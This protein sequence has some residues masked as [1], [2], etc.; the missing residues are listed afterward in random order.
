MLKNYFKL[1]LFFLAINLFLIKNSYSEIVKEIKVIGNDRISSKTIE[2]FANVSINDNL[3]QSNINQILKDLYNTNFFNND[4][5]TLKNNVLMISVYENP[6]INKIQI[7][8][9]KSKRIKDLILKNSILKSRSSFDQLLLK[10]DKENIKKTLKD[11]GY[12]F[13]SVETFIEDLNNNKIN[14]KY[15]FNLG[16]KAKIKKISFIGDKKFKDRKLKS[17][18]VSEENKFWKFITNKKFVNEGIISL[19]KRLLKNFYLNKGYYDV[20][21]DTSLQN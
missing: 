7:D 15:N 14:L 1:I 10:R 4:T 16:E 13:P 21:I 8:G 6:I 18:I 11:L 2:T 17:I 5:I 9:I 19:D 20:I 3:D 12:Y